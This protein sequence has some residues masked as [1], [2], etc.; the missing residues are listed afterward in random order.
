MSSNLTFARSDVRNALEELRH[1]NKQAARSLAQ[2]AIALAP[3]FEDPWLV[4]A[5]VSEPR[6]SLEYLKQAL[7]INP[8]SF[9]ARHGLLEVQRRLERISR[10]RSPQAVDQAPFQAAQPTEQPDYP[11]P[12]QPVS[13]LFSKKTGKPW[14]KWLGLFS[15]FGMAMVAIVIAIIAISQNTNVKAVGLP[16]SPPEIIVLQ[17]LATATATVTPTPA[18]TN[19]PTVTPIPTDTPLPT[20]TD[21]PEPTATPSPI[22]SP[23][24][25]QADA[26]AGSDSQQSGASSNPTGGKRIVVYISKQRMYAYQGDT[27]VYNFIVSTGAYNGTRIGT[28]SILDKI[29][30]AWSDPWGFW[31][32]HWMGIYWAGVTENGIHALPVLTNGNVIWGDGLGTPISHGCIVLSTE[33]ARLLFNWASIGTKVQIL[34]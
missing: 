10:K 21:T 14:L 16:T 31:M 2:H 32:P 17:S 27:L 7:R 28:F 24:P 30:R 26:S 22:P 23:V 19:T 4:L 15:I 9:R 5:A 6:P 1:G 18:P 34:R 20:P 8:D 29:T 12:P 11:P 25:A 3:D 33:D 13:P